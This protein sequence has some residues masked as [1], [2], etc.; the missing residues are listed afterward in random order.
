MPPDSA[1]TYGLINISA[2]F[3]HSLRSFSL[4]EVIFRVSPEGAMDFAL[5]RSFFSTAKKQG[6][7]I[8]DALARDP[9]N[10]AISLRLS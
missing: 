6:W 4:F 8:I 2:R 10:L 7:N 9:S 5:I 3:A 1:F